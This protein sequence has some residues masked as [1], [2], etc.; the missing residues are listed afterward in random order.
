MYLALF[1]LKS[2]GRKKLDNQ[3]EASGWKSDRAKELDFMRLA[4]KHPLEV[5]NDSPTCSAPFHSAHTGE[6]LPYA[7]HC[8]R[9]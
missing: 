6:K 5:Y 1:F 9:P 3:V 8:S 2:L 4:K 7:M